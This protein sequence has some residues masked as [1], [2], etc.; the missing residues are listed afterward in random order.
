VG[1][2]QINDCSGA[3]TNCAAGAGAVYLY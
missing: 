2:N 1:G 3:A